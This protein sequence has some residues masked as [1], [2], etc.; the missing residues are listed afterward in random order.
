MTLDK[1]KLRFNQ[2]WQQDMMHDSL[3]QKYERQ[4]AVLITL[5]EIEREIFVI[6]TT[7][8]KHLVH[9]PGQVCFPGGKQEKDDKS[10]VATALRETHEEIGIAPSSVSVIG[11]LPACNT[12]SG[13]CV[14][15]VVAHLTHKVDL[16]EDL[17]ID[18]NEVAHVFQVPLNFLMNEENYIVQDINR[19]G[20][21]HSVYFIP[22]EN[23]LI[24]GATASMLNSL[25]A[26][27]NA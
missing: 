8:A 26:H 15:P 4:A 16:H 2:A 13:F 27:I 10:L 25:R 17:Q 19:R 7:R 12:V 20:Q 11:T 14:T 23:H 5:Q 21:A 22:Y 6:F 9:H 3:G 24:W 18:N 1:F